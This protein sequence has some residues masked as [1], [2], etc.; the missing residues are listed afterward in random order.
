MTTP[1]EKLRHFIEEKC[2]LH[3]PEGITLASGKISNYYLDCRVA[4]LDP[5]SLPLVAEI[6]LER[7][8][9]LPE[10]PGAIGGAIVGAV[11]ITAAVVQLS[12]LRGTPI[13]GFMVRREVKTHGTQKKIENPPAR[14]TKVVIV[15]DVV[16]TGGST[17]DAIASAEEAGLKVVAVM[18]LVDREE[19]GGE[20]I[21]KRVPLA[22]YQPL[23]VKSDFAA[24]RDP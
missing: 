7:I 2:L 17:L 3:R 14:G 12:A 1:R 18:P 8:G 22:S 24:L 6:V 23:F 9:N 11:P 13:A 16:T 10:K 19:G 15:E 20:A 5:R 4:V 21:R